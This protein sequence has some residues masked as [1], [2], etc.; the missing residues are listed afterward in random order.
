MCRHMYVVN[1]DVKQP[2]HLTSPLLIKYGVILTAAAVNA[3]KFSNQHT[4]FTI[5]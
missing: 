5:V 2:I 4:I 1:C 3:V